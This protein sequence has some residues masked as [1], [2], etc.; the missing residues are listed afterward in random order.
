MLMVLPE[1]TQGTVL[2]KTY[3]VKSFPFSYKTD[4]REKSVTKV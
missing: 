3:P 2:Q 1:L 4:E